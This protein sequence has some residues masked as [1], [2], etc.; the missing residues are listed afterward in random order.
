MDAS[1]EATLPIFYGNLEECIVED[2]DINLS[3]LNIVAKKCLSNA[4]IIAQSIHQCT[5]VEGILQVKNDCGETEYF[6]HAWNHDLERDVFFDKTIIEYEK[7][8]THKETKFSYKHFRSCEYDVSEANW[9]SDR[10]LFKYN[11]QE[12]INKLKHKG[13]F[14]ATLSAEELYQQG[15]RYLRGNGVKAD[16][17]KA[18][19]CF[20]QAISLGN[21][22]EAKRELGYLLLGD[23]LLH[24]DA[25]DLDGLSAEIKRQKRGEQLIEEAAAEGDVLAKKWYIKKN[26]V[27][28]FAFFL[29]AFPKLS[30]YLEQKRRKKLAME[31]KNALIAAG[32]PELLYEKAVDAVVQD[33]KV[34]EQL[35]E[36]EYAPTEYT[37]GAWY[38]NGLYYEKDIKKAKYWLTRSLEHGNLNA[39]ELLDKM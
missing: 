25:S 30:V 18:A 15:E 36:Q 10:A 31:Y 33:K 28:L 2:V 19:E 26:D 38:S 27:N 12:I 1:F 13:H 23:G 7:Y 35:A 6:R 16:K 8:I 9:R 14:M 22:L 21:I 34:I 4:I 37:L 3:H 39:K 20:E 11:Y 29:G 5:I 17:K 24:T 32:D